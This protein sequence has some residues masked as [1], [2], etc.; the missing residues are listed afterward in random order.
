MNRSVEKLLRRKLRI[1][2]QVLHNKRLRRHEDKEA[3]STNH[4]T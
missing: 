1:A 3:C 4:F 2:C